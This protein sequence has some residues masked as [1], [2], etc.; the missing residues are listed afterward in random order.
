MK[1]PV[2]VI[3]SVL[4]FISS[5]FSANL[6]KHW[7]ESNGFGT[8]TKGGLGGKVIKVTNLSSSGSG[9]LHDALLKQS[10]KRLIVFEVGGVID[11]SNWG[12]IKNG[13]VTVAGQ[14]APYPG[15]TL[16]KSHF[17]VDA[18]DVVVSHIAIRLGDQSGEKDVADIIGGGNNVVFNH[19]AISW[20]VDEGI[21]ISAAKN[22]T[23]YKCYIAEQF[24]HSPAHK[25]FEHSKGSLIQKGASNLSIIKSVYAFNC[26]R[27]P[28]LHSGA[29]CAMLN[30]MIYGWA[31]G[32]DDSSQDYHYLISLAG[33]SMSV[34]GNVA[35][36]GPE[37]VGEHL[38]SAHKGKAGSIYVKDNIIVDE[39]GKALKEHDGKNKILSEPPLWPTNFKAEPAEDVCYEIIRTVGPRPGNREPIDKRII[40]HIATGTGKIIDSQE[41]VGGFP[42]YKETKHTLQVPSGAQAQQDWLDELEDKIAVDREIDLKRIYSLVGSEAND[43]FKGN[44]SITHQKADITKAKMVQ[45]S[46]TKKELQASLTLQS[47]AAVSLKICDL[48]GKTVAHRSQRFLEKGNHKLTIDIQQLPAGLYICRLKTGNTLQNHMYHLYR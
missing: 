8:N 15:I 30:S 28:R 5:S 21:S 40:G 17:V 42:S 18:P 14:T 29:Q 7:H 34:V 25:E 10:G 37:S 44:T 32:R 9:S 31:P 46:S 4:L 3:F 38:V 39:E 35:I 6:P 45:Y 23:L 12:Y 26:L 47:S 19:V 20:G 16:I 43:K 1:R 13:N 2:L 24:S 48:A 41:D 33:A 22:V 11:I 36:Q 27:M